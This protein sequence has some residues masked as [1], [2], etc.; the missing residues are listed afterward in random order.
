MVVDSFGFMVLKNTRLRPWMR[1]NKDG[2]PVP[3]ID[4]LA[5]QYDRSKYVRRP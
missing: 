3:D 1:L 4:F 5:T 2:A